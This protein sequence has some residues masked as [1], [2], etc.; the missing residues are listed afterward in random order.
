[1]YLDAALF[2]RIAVEH[3]DRVEREGVARVDL[4]E[5]VHERVDP[6]GARR[7]EDGDRARGQRRD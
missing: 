2:A 7:A 5:V 1:M 3:P 6:R 4:D